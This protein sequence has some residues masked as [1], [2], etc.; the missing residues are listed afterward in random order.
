[1]ARPKAGIEAYNNERIIWQSV[2]QQNKLAFRCADRAK[3]IQQIQRLHT[4]RML[5]RANT[6]EGT[7]SFFD[8]Y[9]IKNPDKGTT[10]IIEPRSPIEDLEILT[11]G[12]SFEEARQQIADNDRT[13]SDAV[14]RDLGYDPSQINPDA[15]LDLE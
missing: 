15:P 10:I 9:V 7:Y 11:P 12:V 3:T 4:F 1:M 13:K 2:L 8:N 6:F 5:D 14:I